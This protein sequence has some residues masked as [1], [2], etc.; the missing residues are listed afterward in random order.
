MASD[1]LIS[2]LPPVSSRGSP[3]SQS[4]CWPPLSPLEETRV[5]RMKPAHPRAP[6][7]ADRANHRADAKV[8]ELPGTS[9]EAPVQE[10][11]VCSPRRPGV[12]RGLGAGVSQSTT[13]G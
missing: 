7:L 1:A 11:G 3:G 8:R 12:C 9:G 2:L 5:S 13:E 4:L 6:G 10:E